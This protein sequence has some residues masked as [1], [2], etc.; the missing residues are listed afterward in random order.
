MT[1]LPFPEQASGR[2]LLDKRAL[3]RELGMS[4]SWVNLQMRV[5]GLPYRKLGAGRGA[6][7]R[8]RLSEVEAWMRRSA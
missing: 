4:V 5:G 3:A 2:A 7:V 1:V 8:F 6:S